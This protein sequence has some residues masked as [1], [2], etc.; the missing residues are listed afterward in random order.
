MVNKRVINKMINHFSPQTTEHIKPL[1]HQTKT[2]W[3][4][5]LEIQIFDTTLCDK[6][7]QWDV[8]GSGKMSLLSSPIHL[9]AMKSMKYF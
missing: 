1:N 9:T 3:H 5:A 4:M 6:V 8:A 7:G 2:P